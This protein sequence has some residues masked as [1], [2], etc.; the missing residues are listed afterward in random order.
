VLVGI[1][2][3]PFE[4]LQP[5]AVL[6][7]LAELRHPADGRP[8]L[9]EGKDWFTKKELVAAVGVNPQSLARKLRKDGRT[10]R[11]SGKPTAIPGNWSN[12]CATEPSP[13]NRDLTAIKGYTRL[14]E[15]RK[16]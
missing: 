4:D 2:A 5:S 9:E 15:T 10:G 3:D 14:V 8:P 11:G 7:F 6:E 16:A 12:R 1:E 13:S